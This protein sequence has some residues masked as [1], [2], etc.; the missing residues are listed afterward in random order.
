MNSHEQVPPT[1]PGI[2]TFY[3]AAQ[4]GEVP[5]VL[6]PQ[7]EYVG[8]YTTQQAYYGQP[9]LAQ[10]H[11]GH[12][13]QG[14]SATY[15][16]QTHASI[17]ASAPS[18][19]FS[20]PRTVYSDHAYDTSS[21]SSSSRESSAH[22]RGSVSSS[23]TAQPRATRAKRGS[24]SQGSGSDR[25]TKRPSTRSR[26]DG[27]KDDFMCV[28]CDCLSGECPEP[29][30]HVHKPKK[31]HKEQTSRSAQAVVLQNLEDYAQIA[32]DLNNDDKK[33]QPGNKKKSGLTVDKKQ[34]LSLT[35]I[36]VDEGLQT[37]AS[38]G[39]PAYEAFAHRVQLRHQSNTKLSGLVP[40]SILSGPSGEDLCPHILARVKCD[41]QIQCRKDRR[42]G[43]CHDNLA[44]IMG[45]RSDGS[46]RRSSAASDSRS[47]LSTP[48]RH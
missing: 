1:L 5:E 31:I 26:S 40:G 3:T 11:S 22:P 2:N 32:L 21:V 43:A 18:A 41:D 20:S 15:N 45:S 33:Q 17:E 27:P 35:E 9:P 8:R 34:G 36:I 4:Q 24:E 47:K 23:T 16:G 29:K 6:R 37:I 28:N 13:H 38:L 44:R 19:S 10:H 42:G 39:A 46:S 7:R 14:P 25:S 30:K 12:F 48:R